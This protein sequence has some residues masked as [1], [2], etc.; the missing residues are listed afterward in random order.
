MHT[1]PV[2]N[3]QGLDLATVRYG[4]D[5]KEVSIHLLINKPYTQKLIK[6]EKKYGDN[7]CVISRVHYRVKCFTE[8][9]GGHSL[10]SIQCD[11]RK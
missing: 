10:V 7:I 4:P 3:R 1:P 11:H 6:S 2:N 5:S 9:K 8:K